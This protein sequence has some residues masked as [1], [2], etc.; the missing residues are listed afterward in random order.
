MAAPDG[1]SCCAWSGKAGEVVRV[2]FGHVRHRGSG[3]PLRLP[4]LVEGGALDRRADVETAD[5][6]ALVGYRRGV[7]RLQVVALR[8]Q[9]EPAGDVR[10][11]TDGAGA[12]RAQDSA[13]SSLE[14]GRQELL[15]QGQQRVERQ[16]HERLGT[17][18]SQGGDRNEP[19]GGDTVVE[20]VGVADRAADLSGQPWHGVGVGQVGGEDVRSRADADQVRGQRFQRRLAGHLDDGVAG[21]RVAAG[22][23]PA[24]AG[25]APNTAMDGGM[26][27]LILCSTRG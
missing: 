10:H 21:L 22:D 27:G 6:D 5:I 7:Q 13:V 1:S 15:H 11:A 14:H 8:G 16:R 23:G 25:P 24:E 18:G 2:D 20:R 4:P 19:A 17:L 3:R 26:D 9:G 12:L